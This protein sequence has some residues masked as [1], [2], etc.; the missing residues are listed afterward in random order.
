MIVSAGLAMAIVAAGVLLTSWVPLGIRLRLEERI[1]GG[2]VVGVLAT[3]VC[4]F[5]AFLAVGFGG[6]TVL[7]G[8]GVPL[9]VGGVGALG[10]PARR[11]VWRSELASAR[12]RLALPTRRAA[13]LRPLVAFTAVAAVVSTRTLSLGYQTSA[14]GIRAGSLSTWADWAAHLAYAGSF[15]YGDNRELELPIAT[16]EGFRY[17]FLADFF[18]AVFTVSGATLMQSLL[19]ATWLL[20]IALPP[21][22]WCVVL[23]LVGSRT[24]A[25]IAVTLFTL[26]GGLGAWYFI[27]DVEQDGWSVLSALPRTYAR[28]GEQHIWVDNTISAS[29]YAQRSTQLGWAT[30]ALATEEPSRTTA[31]DSRSQYPF[32]VPLVT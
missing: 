18:G 5:V 14:E 8:T 19:L 9:V 4:T 20:A 10:S 22:L 24:T 1:A 30:G 28:I 15:A 16:G 12:R 32:Q 26:G 2:I 23:R 31:S 3:S 13:S 29:F 27:R 11:G 25:A 7:F 6:A 17:H 21:L